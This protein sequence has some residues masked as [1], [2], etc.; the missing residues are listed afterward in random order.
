MPV[1]LWSC[2]MKALSNMHM[3]C[4]SFL[5]GTYKVKNHSTT[6]MLGE[7]GLI[8]TANGILL[9]VSFIGVLRAFLSIIFS[10]WLFLSVYHFYVSLPYILYF[11]CIQSL[12]QMLLCVST[13]VKFDH[14]ITIY[15]SKCLCFTFNI[16]FRTL[17]RFVLINCWFQKLQEI[18][19]VTCPIIVLNS[20][21]RH[22]GSIRNH[23]FIWNAVV[24]WLLLHTLHIPLSCLDNVTYAEVISF[25]EKCCKPFETASKSSNFP[26]VADRLS[27]WFTSC[28]NLL[29]TLSWMNE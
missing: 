24:L 16:I 7:D 19:S 1:T 22:W 11:W 12:S 18:A 14:M 27:Y 17:S 10:L 6:G 5:W 23:I 13:R 20:T 28:H 29:V 21:I 9:D 8:I 2:S 25:V 3:H 26:V 4:V 15:R